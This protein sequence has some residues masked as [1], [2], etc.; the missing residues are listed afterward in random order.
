MSQKS[1]SF[2]H[3]KRKKS[4]HPYIDLRNVNCQQ[5][6]YLWVMAMVCIFVYGL[7]IYILSVTTKTVIL[8]FTRGCTDMGT[9]KVFHLKVYS[10]FIKMHSIRTYIGTNYSPTLGITVPVNTTSC[11]TTVI[12]HAVCIVKIVVNNWLELTGIRYYTQL[13]QGRVG[14]GRLGQARLGYVVH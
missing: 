5:T 11:L 2:L 13:G 3:Q 10:F 6:F 1:Q 4:I 12:K 7:Y 9:I 8:L 14:Q